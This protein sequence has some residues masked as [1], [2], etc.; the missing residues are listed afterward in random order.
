[1][2]TWIDVG[3]TGKGSDSPIFMYRGRKYVITNKRGQVVYIHLTDLTVFNQNTWVCMESLGGDNSSRGQRKT[4]R[5]AQICL[6]DLFKWPGHMQSPSMDHNLSRWP[7]I[8]GRAQKYILG[9]C[10]S[11][12]WAI[13]IDV[14]EN[15]FFI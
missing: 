15:C 11:E 13:W 8:E 6:T 4:I 14:L 10:S 1:M 5:M 7:V 3:L 12:W 2:V 9:V